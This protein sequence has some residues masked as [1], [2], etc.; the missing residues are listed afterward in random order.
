M[1]WCILTLHYVVCA[2]LAFATASELPGA[3]RPEIRTDD[4]SPKL[5]QRLDAVNERFTQLENSVQQLIVKL[6]T[7][8]QREEPDYD[9][10]SSKSSWWSNASWVH[11]L[12]VHE[13]W[14]MLQHLNV[15]CNPFCQRLDRR[16][17][18]A[19][20]KKKLYWV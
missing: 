1:H 7:Q 4:E 9:N 5:L 15:L 20:L 3:D 13:V 10:D 11:V 2:V 12:F 8:E 14:I 18:I 6:S 19:L 16:Y 17:G